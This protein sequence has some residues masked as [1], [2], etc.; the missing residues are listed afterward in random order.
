MG[1]WQGAPG[2]LPGTTGVTWLALGRG[3]HT[4]SLGR[5]SLPAEGPTKPAQMSPHPG[6]FCDS[7]CH[8]TCLDPCLSDL[9]SLVERNFLM[10]AFQTPKEGQPPRPT[11]ATVYVQGPTAPW[12]SSPPTAPVSPWSVLF[13]LPAPCPREAGAVCLAEHSAGHVSDAQ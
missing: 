2:A 11:R 13:S 9:G 8:T 12:H 3:T 6:S 7:L 1:M 4:P 10:E 5:G